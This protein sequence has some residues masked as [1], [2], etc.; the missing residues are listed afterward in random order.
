MSPSNEVV[1]GQHA[2]GDAASAQEL[3]INIS[4]VGGVLVS[5]RGTFWDL[6][7][8]FATNNATPGLIGGTGSASRRN[9]TMN[10]TMADRTGPKQYY[11]TLDAP[12]Q[13]N[14]NVGC[15]LT[16][17]CGPVDTIVVKPI[18]ARIETGVFTLYG[19]M[20]E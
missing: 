8:V 2:I 6:N 5:A 20:S 17:S 1:R 10:F 12:G 3:Y 11:G 18:T 15:G 9:G 19:L 16:A 4:D 13:D 14:M 7:G